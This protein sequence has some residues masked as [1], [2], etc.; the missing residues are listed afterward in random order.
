[1]A[2]GKRNNGSQGSLFISSDELFSSPNAFYEALDRLLCE[3]GFDVFVS[4]TFREL[5]AEGIG[6]PGVCIRM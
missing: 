4:E 2:L 3:N 1:M 5:Y 6:R